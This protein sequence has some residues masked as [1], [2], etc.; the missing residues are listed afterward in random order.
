MLK[1]IQPIINYNDDDN[2]VSS[3]ALTVF[4]LPCST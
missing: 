4:P 2:D 3:N 1:Y